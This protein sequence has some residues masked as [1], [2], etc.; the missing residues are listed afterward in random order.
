MNHAPTAGIRRGAIVTVS[1]AG[2]FGKPRPALVI[3][4]NYL[5]DA[6]LASVIVALITGHLED[7]PLFRL[8]VESKPENGLRKTSQ[9]MLDKLVAVRSSRI[10]KIVGHL[11]QPTML[12]INRSLALVVGLAE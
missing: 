3:Q 6:G 2:N 9:V 5:I 7:A 1:G 8:T 4:S 10:G 12:N 11:D